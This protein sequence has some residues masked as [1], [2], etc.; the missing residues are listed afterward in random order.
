[1]LPLPP[2][3]EGESDEAHV[4]AINTRVARM[5]DIL[6][7]KKYYPA[8]LHDNGRYYGP[9]ESDTLVEFVCTSTEERLLTSSLIDKLHVDAR[10]KAEAQIANSYE[11]K[12]IADC[13]ITG[14]QRDGTDRRYGPTK[15]KIVA[16]YYSPIMYEF[17]MRVAYEVLP[18]K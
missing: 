18:K 1:V 9:G 15:K 12:D 6:Y 13:N 3:D 5:I 4:L 17:N 14:R 11:I 8:G 7:E 2:R 10:K 16:Q